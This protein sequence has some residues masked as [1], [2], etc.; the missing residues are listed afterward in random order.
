MLKKISIILYNMNIISNIYE[1]IN[2]FLVNEAQ[3]VL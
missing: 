3:N 2:L 1:I